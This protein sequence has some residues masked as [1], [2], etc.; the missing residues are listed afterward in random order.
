MEDLDVLIEMRR[1]G[2]WD[3]SE[4]KLTKEGTTFNGFLTKHIILASGNTSLRV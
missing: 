3:Y 1:H 4:D 2:E